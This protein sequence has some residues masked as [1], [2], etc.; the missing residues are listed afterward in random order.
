[1]DDAP[2]LAAALAAVLDDPRLAGDLRS[3]ALAAC[4]RFSWARSA[5]EHRAIYVALTDPRYPDGPGPGAS[6]STR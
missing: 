6:S 5:A 4:E 3:A 1:V 2:A